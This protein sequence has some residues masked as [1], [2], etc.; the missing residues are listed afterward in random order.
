MI[1]PAVEVNSPAR[2]FNKVDL[3]FPLAPII[4]M[5]SF[6]PIENVMSEK[7]L[8]SGFPLYAKERFL[9]FIMV[10]PGQG[11][12]LNRKPKFFSVLNFSM[13]PI[14]SIIFKRD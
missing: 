10:F 14:F 3:P 13:V 4:P 7:I 12:W 11:R 9:T 5:R 6:R 1:S 8:S 2:Q